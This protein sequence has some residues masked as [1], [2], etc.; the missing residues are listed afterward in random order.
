M[1]FFFVFKIASTILPST[2]VNVRSNERIDYS[3]TEYLSIQ[4]WDF[5]L[6]PCTASIVLI[7]VPDTDWHL[8][9]VRV[10]VGLKATLGKKQWKPLDR[11]QFYQTRKVTEWSKICPPL[12]SKR[13][14]FWWKRN[15]NITQIFGCKTTSG[16]SNAAGKEQK[17]YSSQRCMLSVNAFP[18]RFLDISWTCMDDLTGSVQESW[19]HVEYS[20][21][22]F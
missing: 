10:I 20:L 12:Y 9:C 6:S 2:S 13:L 22:P 1:C 16:V 14:F 19:S 17:D 5:S 8:L 21:R 4:K 7:A 3:P 11:I 18:Q 15:W